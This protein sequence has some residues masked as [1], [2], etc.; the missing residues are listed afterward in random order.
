[1]LM[2]NLLVGPCDFYVFYCYAFAYTRY[3]V[4]KYIIVIR[5]LDFSFLNTNCVFFLCITSA[6]AMLSGKCS[7][8]L[9]LVLA[10][11]LQVYQNLCPCSELLT[12]R[13]CGLT[14]CASSSLP[15]YCR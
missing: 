5:Y 8:V 7:A 4:W 10:F 9:L 6:T 1:M 14:T 11:Y 12:A 2:N 13:F 3:V 15:T